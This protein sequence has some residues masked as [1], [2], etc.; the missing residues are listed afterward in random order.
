MTGSRACTMVRTVK[1]VEVRGT[2][3]RDRDWTRARSS[4]PRR[5]ARSWSGLH[6]S[7]LLA[8]SCLLLFAVHLAIAL[9]VAH[10]TIYG[11][12]PGYLGNA[13]YLVFGTGATGQGYYPG[14]SLLL[15][16]ADLL[17][18]SPLAYYRAA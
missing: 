5:I 17:F 15:I 11:D 4:V 14:Y 7:T 9:S 6:D 8:G 2:R 13:H 12:E 18:R 16:P 3:R 1:D 10:P